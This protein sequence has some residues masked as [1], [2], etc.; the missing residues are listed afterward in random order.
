M[1]KFGRKGIIPFSIIALTALSPLLVRA[2][3]QHAGGKWV[4]SG[5]NWLF[6]GEN[7]EKKTGWI[8][9]KGKK[10][11]IDPVKGTLGISWIRR[12]RLS[13]N[14]Q[15]AGSGL[16]ATATTSMPRPERWRRMRRRRMA[17]LFLPAENG[18]MKRENPFISRNSV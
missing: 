6:F 7:G 18:Q 1:K 14:L 4:Q 3:E 12:S 5:E 11:Y 10:Y 2:E 17:T 15:K 8:E 16:T 13:E 9:D